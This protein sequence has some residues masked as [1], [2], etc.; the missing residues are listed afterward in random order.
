MGKK[1]SVSVNWEDLFNRG[2]VEA[3]I[4]KEKQSENSRV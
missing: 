3:P 4:G 1:V 2:D